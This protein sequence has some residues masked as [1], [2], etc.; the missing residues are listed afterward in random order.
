MAC[1]EFAGLSAASSLMNLY[2]ACELS[3]HATSGRNVG[4][5]HLNLNWN[6]YNT[7]TDI[8]IYMILYVHT[9]YIYIYQYVYVNIYIYIM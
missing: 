8:C 1:N 6:A 4:E 9:L 5:K 3:K 7:N 2:T